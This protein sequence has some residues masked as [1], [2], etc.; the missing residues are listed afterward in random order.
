MVAL[1]VELTVVVVVLLRPPAANPEVD[2]EDVVEEEIAVVVLL[3]AASLIAAPRSLCAAWA[4]LLLPAKDDVV[5]FLRQNTVV[6]TYEGVVVVV[7][8]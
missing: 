5:A 3:L 2:E 6:S 4:P 1:T 8:V 7:H